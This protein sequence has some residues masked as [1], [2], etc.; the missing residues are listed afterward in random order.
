[1]R[2]CER[3]KANLARSLPPAPAKGSHSERAQWSEESREF[4]LASIIVA[5]QTLSS[6]PESAPA[7]AAEGSAVHFL[8]ESTAGSSTRAPR[9]LGM[10]NLFRCWRCSPRERIRCYR[11]DYSSHPITCRGYRS[12][13]TS[14]L[15]YQHCH[16]DRSSFAIANERSRGT[17]VSFPQA[18]ANHRFLDSHPAAARSK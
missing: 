18:K 3:G 15:I 10:T 7:D 13:W 14:R 1:M 17:C 9:S 8:R 11:C 5:L 2:F 6:R 12:T 4:R 16:P